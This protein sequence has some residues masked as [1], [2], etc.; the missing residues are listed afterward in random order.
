VAYLLH[1]LVDVIVDGRFEAVQS[2]DNA[3][4]DLEERLLDDEVPDRDTQHR[5]QRYPR[6]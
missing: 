2:L 6:R 1:G 3:I 5:A 4:E